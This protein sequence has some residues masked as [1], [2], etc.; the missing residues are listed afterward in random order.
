MPSRGHYFPGSN[1][2]LKTNTT[3]HTDSKLTVTERLL[4]LFNHSVCSPH[5]HDK[6]DMT[7]AIFISIRCSSGVCVGLNE[8]AGDGEEPRVQVNLGLGQSP[9]AADVKSC[10]I[11]LVLLLKNGSH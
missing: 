3:N 11:L 6:T 2:N 7:V 8:E 10:D 4:E 9:G 5:I 1:C